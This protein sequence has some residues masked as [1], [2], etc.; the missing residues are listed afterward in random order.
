MSTLSTSASTVKS[1]HPRPAPLSVSELKSRIDQGR[2][3]SR[4]YAEAA[5]N[6]LAR[7][8]ATKSNPLPSELAHE[9][10]QMAGRIDAAAK[11]DGGVVRDM[12]AAVD[13]VDAPD[14]LTQPASKEFASKVAERLSKEIAEKRDPLIPADVIAGILEKAHFLDQNTPRHGAVRAIGA[15]MG[16]RT[17]SPATALCA[18]RSRIDELRPKIE[19]LERWL[20]STATSARA[21]HPN[22]QGITLI[23]LSLDLIRRQLPG[24]LYRPLKAL[25]GNLFTDLLSHDDYSLLQNF[26]LLTELVETS[27]LPA[28]EGCELPLARFA[29]EPALVPDIRR[30]AEFRQEIG[31]HFDRAC[32]WADGRGAHIELDD[33]HFSLLKINLREADSWFPAGAKVEVTLQ[34]EKMSRALTGQNRKEFGEAWLAVHRTVMAVNH[35]MNR[36]RW[37]RNSRVG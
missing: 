16:L 19:E 18:V 27:L 28:T 20:G 25:A 33:F 34:I 10:L 2:Q 35:D 31:M 26:R 4:P 3:S 32:E 1:R 8:L 12:G 29:D 11:T 30:F 14:K 24:Q 36:E 13:L 15:A 5:A 23:G 37:S 22:L 17:D 21:A 7:E 6:L 9:I